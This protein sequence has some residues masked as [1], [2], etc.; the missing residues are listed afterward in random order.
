MRLLKMLLA[1]AAIGV[2]VTAF[3]DFENETWLIPVRPGGAGGMDLEDEPEPVLGYDGMDQDTLLDWLADA[4]VD[5]DT[6]E[7]MHRY[8]LAGRGREPVL[9]AIEDRLG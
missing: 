2:I 7:R 3:R 8:E 9:S 4:A 1:G 5:A 6:L